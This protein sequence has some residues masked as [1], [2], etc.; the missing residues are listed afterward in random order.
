MV[1]ARTA[2]LMSSDLINEL[3]ITGK[4]PETA[5]A[6]LLAKYSTTPEIAPVLRTETWYL[7][8]MEERSAGRSRPLWVVALNWNGLEASSSPRTRT[9]WIAMRS[10]G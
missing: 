8:A 9:D 10:V 6:A 7:P 5:K 3:P 1:P 2:I 4:E